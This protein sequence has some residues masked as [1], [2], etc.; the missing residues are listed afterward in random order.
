MTPVAKFMA[1]AALAISYTVVVLKAAA[2]IGIVV[3]T[4]A[5]AYAASCIATRLSPTARRGQF[6]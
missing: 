1:F 3:M 6:S 4:F 2:W 5:L